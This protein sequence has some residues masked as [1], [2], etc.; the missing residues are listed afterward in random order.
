MGWSYIVLITKASTG[1]TVLAQAVALVAAASVA[2]WHVGRV[3]NCV[4]VA[5][6]SLLCVVGVAQVASKQIDAHSI[7]V[8]IINLTLVDIHA[9]TL[10]ILLESSVA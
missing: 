6:R 5:Q 4:M 1:E 3:V 7:A 9:I 10:C 8:S 2:V